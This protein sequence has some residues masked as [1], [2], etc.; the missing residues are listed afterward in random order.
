MDVLE[1]VDEL[2]V[3][4]E[5]FDTKDATTA[6]LDELNRLVYTHKIVVLKNQNLTDQEFVDFSG[7]LGEPVPYLQKNYHHPEHPLIFVSSNVHVDGKKMGVARTGGYWHSDTAFQERPVPFTMLYPKI[8]PKD[9]TR[10]TLFIDLEKA[11]RALP[12]DLKRRLDKST[13][14]HSGRWK[15][16]V[17]KQDAGFDISEIL[18]MIDQVQPP[19]RHPAVIVHPVT[20]ERIIYATR[21]FTVGVADVEPHEG[22]ALL[23]ELFAFVERDEFVST[24]KW[25]LGDIIIW[26]NRF[27]AH[28]AGRTQSPND[29][30]DAS[31]AKEEPTMVYRIIVDDG[32]PMYLNGRSNA[33]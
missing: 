16:K 17:R 8:M 29:H 11:Y 12:D 22:A 13:F 27:L 15:Y 25:E 14:L 3:A 23:E 1:S 32:Q 5:D 24:F 20:R 6:K 10:T 28:R 7:Q 2:G 26:D 18:A 30:L 33:S 9:S 4:V 21:G 31:A 19:V